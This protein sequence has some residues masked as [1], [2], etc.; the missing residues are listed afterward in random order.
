MSLAFALDRDRELD[1]VRSL[2]RRY[3]DAGPRDLARLLI[4]RARWWAAGAGLLTGLPGNLLIAAPAAAADRGALLRLE[5]RLAARVALLFDE[6]FLS[7]PQ[8]ETRLLDA[9]FGSGGTQALLRSLSWQGGLG[10]ARATARRWLRPDA[11]GRLSG[12]LLRTLGIQAAERGLVARS[13]PVVGG[14]IGGARNF[15]ELTRIGEEV[16]RHFEGRAPTPSGPEP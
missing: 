5:M 7:D 15:R 1:F 10:A 9:F 6:S 13:V 12:A 14:L 4:N 16:I 11:S 3:P 2:K 8:P